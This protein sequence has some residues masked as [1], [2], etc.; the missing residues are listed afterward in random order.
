MTNDQIAVIKARYK[1]IRNQETL[2]T[3]RIIDFLIENIPALIVAL[4]EMTAE[5]DCWGKR[6]KA[7]EWAIKNGCGACGVC[8][9]IYEC[10]YDVCPSCECSS[11][12]TMSYFEFDVERF[13]ERSEDGAIH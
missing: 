12:S 2:S 6:A 9:R 13:A 8:K 1:L 3:G 7:L 11:R 4:E 5:R 10:T